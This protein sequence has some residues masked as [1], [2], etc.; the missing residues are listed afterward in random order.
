MINKLMYIDELFKHCYN[1][2]AFSINKYHY[3]LV[4]RQNILSGLTGKH[5]LFDWGKNCVFWTKWH[6][7][8]GIAVGYFWRLIF[9]VWY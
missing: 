9:S 7:L 3:L 8:F 1:R 6:I 4:M 2:I 5:A